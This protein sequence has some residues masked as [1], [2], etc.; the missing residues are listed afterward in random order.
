[1]SLWILVFT[2]Q[3]SD[4]DFTGPQPYT[5]YEECQEYGKKLESLQ[6]DPRVTSWSCFEQG[7]IHHPEGRHR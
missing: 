5:S 7:H 6:D 3:G 2:L 1:M 4:L